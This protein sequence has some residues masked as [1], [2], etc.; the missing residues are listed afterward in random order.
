MPNH[1]HL[2]LSTP[3]EDLGIVMKLVMGSVTKTL[4]RIS[5]RSG[6]VFGARYH[7]TLLDSER[8]FACAFKYAY[9]NPIKATLCE[10]VEDYQYSTLQGLMGNAPLPIPIYFPFGGNSYSIVPE[11]HTSLM[12]WLNQ[13]F[14]KEYE[15][16][17]KK[18]LKKTRFAPPLDLKKQTI[19]EL[20]DELI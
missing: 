3:N 20:E 15:L 13:P 1:F 14:R 2:V 6:R 19:I 12:N 10:R 7:W 8:Y 17:I 4:N 16:A 18:G 11:E 9:R 5:R